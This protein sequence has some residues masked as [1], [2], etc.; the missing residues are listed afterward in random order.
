[1][2]KYEGKSNLAGKFI[3]NVLCKKNMTKE[4]LCT[5]LQLYGINID[6]RHLYRIIQGTVILKDFE[7]IIICKILDVDYNELKELIK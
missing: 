7:L 2:R 1:M 5:Q 4:Y 6:S 3:E